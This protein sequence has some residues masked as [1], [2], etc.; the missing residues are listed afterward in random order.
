MVRPIITDLEILSQPSEDV[1]NFGA[2]LRVLLDDLA[3]TMRAVPGSRLRQGACALAAPEIGVR[4]RVGVMLDRDGRLLEL[5]NPQQRASSGAQAHLEG[6]VSVRHRAKVVRPSKITI[7]NVGRQGEK[8]PHLILD[9]EQARSF[10]HLADHWDGRL[11][12]DLAATTYGPLDGLPRTRGPVVELG[13]F[14][15]QWEGI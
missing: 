12:T 13:H 9:G 11:L 10:S 6:C 1:T 8:L 7:A 5:I 3:D 2:S 15:A 4:L 14:P